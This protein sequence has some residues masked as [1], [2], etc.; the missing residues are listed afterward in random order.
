MLK[1]ILYSCLLMSCLTFLAVGLDKR[2]SRLGRTRISEA[3]LLWMSWATGMVGG[4]LGMWAFRHK[5]RKTS[6]KIKMLLATLG[7]LMWVLLWLALAP[8]S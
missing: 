6:F 5:T 2:R 1:Y 7:N 3:N 4:W 8:E